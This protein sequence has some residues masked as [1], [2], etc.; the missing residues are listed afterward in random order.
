MINKW[1]LSCCPYYKPST[2]IYQH[3]V[4]ISMPWSDYQAF[5][6]CILRLTAVL[7][8]SSTRPIIITQGFQSFLFSI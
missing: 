3:S 1:P 8:Y 4:P 2:G 7:I 6:G 5:D